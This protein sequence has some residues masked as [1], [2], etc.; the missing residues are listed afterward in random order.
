[1]KVQEMKINNEYVTHVYI[2]KEESTIK[3]VKEKIDELKKENRKVV[4]FSGGSKDTRNTLKQMLQIEKNLL[5][6]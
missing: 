6:N 5:E 2:G 3:E 4:V 1:M